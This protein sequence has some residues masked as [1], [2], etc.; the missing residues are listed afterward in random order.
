MGRGGSLPS[1][2]KKKFF[3]QCVLFSKSPLNV[4]FLKEVTKNVHEYQYSHTSK[5]KK[6]KILL[7]I[8]FYQVV[9]IKSDT[10]FN[11]IKDALGQINND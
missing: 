10:L 11:S 7:L 9:N 1:A 8:G 2:P 3:C 5:L 6:D 4:S